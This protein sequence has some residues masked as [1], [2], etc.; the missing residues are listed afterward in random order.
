MK[1]R[2][3]ES[4]VYERDEDIE[5]M[6]DFYR[7]AKKQDDDSENLINILEGLHKE[8]KELVEI[9]Q[10]IFKDHRHDP[11]YRDTMLNNKRFR[12]EILDKIEHLTEQ[13]D[14][15]ESDRI[16]NLTRADELLNDID[17]PKDYPPQETVY[18]PNGEVADFMD[19]FNRRHHGYP[20][21]IGPLNN[22]PSAGQY[23]DND[24][25]LVLDLNPNPTN[26]VPYTVDWL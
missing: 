11:R 22:E 3:P 23:Y 5:V 17:R 7:V 24:G 8:Y 19:D 12:L 1:R 15:I 10:Q 2:R 18:L 14:I 6:E 25:N 26:Q 9:Y 4:H 21:P 13:L 20:H 16:W